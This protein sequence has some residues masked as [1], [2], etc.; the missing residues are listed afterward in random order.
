MNAEVATKTEFGP[1][2]V[3]KMR[4]AMSRAE[5]A[6]KVGV[7]PLTVY[8]WEL[9]DDAPESRRPRGM[10]AERLR[11]VAEGKEDLASSGVWSSRFARESHALDQEDAAA[12]LPAIDRIF[13]GEV[14]RADDDL[15]R[16]LVSGSLRG[17]AGRALAQAALALGQM[18]ARLDARGAF[19]TVEPALKEADRFTLPPFVEIVVRT[20]AAMVFSAPDGRLF[21]VG[22]LHAQIARVDRIATPETRPDLLLLLQASATEGALA[23]GSGRL[24]VSEVLDTAGEPVTRLYAD[25]LRAR[26]LLESGRGAHV[27]QKLDDIAGSAARL[28]LASF[29]ARAL[30]LRAVCLFDEGADPERILALALRSKEVAARA[31]LSFG[32]HTLLAARAAADACLRLGRLV[33]AERELTD[34]LAA[35]QQ[36]DWSPHPLSASFARLFEYTGRHEEHALGS[37]DRSPSIG[38]AAVT[39]RLQALDAC[40]DGRIAEAVALLEASIATCVAIGDRPEAALG[41]HWLARV[42]LELERP[43][44][45]DRVAASE[46]ELAELGVA[47]PP[48]LEFGDFASTSARTSDGM[49]AAVERLALAGASRALLERELVAIVASMVPDHGVVLEELGRTVAEHGELEPDTWFELGQSSRLGISGQLPE[50]AGERIRVLTTV[51]SLALEVNALRSPVEREAP[52]VGLIGTSPPMKRLRSDIARLAANGVTALI[53]GEP[54]TG[55]AL[56]ARTI[57]DL[58]ERASGPFV[59]FEDDFEAKG[60]TLFFDEIADLSIELQATLLRFLERGDSGVR[61]VAATSRDLARRVAE[62]TFREDLFHRLKVTPVFVPPLRDRT[63]D[64]AALARHF[65]VELTPHGEEPPALGGDALAWLVEQT[66]RGNV[67]EL[68]DTIERV[69]GVSP[70]PRVITRAHLENVPD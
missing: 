48:R 58:S 50:G 33:D 55:K 66:W 31:R 70:V 10:V 65:V 6:R 56:V 14:A 18:M 21:D 38:D 3:R 16:L 29:E 62:G 39:K 47:V 40:R 53:E 44:A 69:V 12:V 46:M 68:R 32:M 35:A 5:F 37:V 43:D 49:L 27:A 64:I 30:A 23:S 59:V 60:G 4:G 57:H 25:E 20:A 36:A 13:R 7:T 67:R 34:G 22:R 52:E 2:N 8:R 28:G 61:T 41:R 11:R 1:E 51:A 54:G 45:E 63:A 19:A 26:I 42:E 9:P 24:D 17:A 15:V